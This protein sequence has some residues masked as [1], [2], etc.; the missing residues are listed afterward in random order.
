MSPPT[1]KTIIIY[2]KVTLPGASLNTQNILITTFS[3]RD[4]NIKDWGRIID[5]IVLPGIS[6]SNPTSIHYFLKKKK[7]CIKQ[8]IKYL[9]TAGM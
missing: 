9:V 3:T 7:L 1:N 8:N 2:G 6:I 5:R 4:T